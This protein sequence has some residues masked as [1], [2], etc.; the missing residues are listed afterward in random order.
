MYVETDHSVVAYILLTDVQALE[1]RSYDTMILAQ[2][3]LLN[4]VNLMFSGFKNHVLNL[5]T[6][7]AW[8]ATLIRPFLT[9]SE[10]KESLLSTESD[11][12]QSSRKWH[13]W[14]YRESKRRLVYCFSGE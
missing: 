9:S 8:L 5:Q 4:V 6:R 13:S 1:S 14:L 3:F 12:V 2:C 10:F 11:S 7:R